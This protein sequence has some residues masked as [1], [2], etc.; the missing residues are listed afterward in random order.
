MAVSVIF[1]IRSTLRVERA[2]R[3]EYS[4]RLPLQ[5]QGFLNSS[6]QSTGDGVRY[7]AF[8]FTGYHLVTQQRSEVEL[9]PHRMLDLTIFP[10]PAALDI[11]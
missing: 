11:R 3:Q 6:P 5:T 2:E 7:S 4:Y 8:T 10:S 9:D 1:S